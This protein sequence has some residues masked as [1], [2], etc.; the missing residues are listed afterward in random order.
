[1][2]MVG[3]GPMP[4][5]TPINVPS[6]QPISAKPRLAQLPAA[7]KPVNRLLKTSTSAS[8]QRRQPLGA[9]EPVR[10]VRQGLPQSIDEDHRGPDGHQQA[11]HDGFAKLEFLPGKS[12]DQHHD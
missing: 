12:S 7:A 3:I 9:T 6:T 4:G 10:A 11:E 8:P 1:M 2:A 5:S